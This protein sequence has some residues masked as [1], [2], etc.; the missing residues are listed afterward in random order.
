M[1]L[2]HQI[3]T[4]ASQIDRIV[5]QPWVY[6]ISGFPVILI[7][8]DTLMAETMAALQQHNPSLAANEGSF[9][10]VEEGFEQ[11]LRRAKRHNTQ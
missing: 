3:L 6:V 8:Q 11:N 10:G 4:L 5:A 1:R 2:L 7:T 9:S